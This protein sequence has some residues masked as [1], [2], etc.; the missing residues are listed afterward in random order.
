MA[1]WLANQSRP[2][3]VSIEGQRHRM[4][5][6]LGLVCHSPEPLGRISWAVTQVVRGFLDSLGVHAQRHRAVLEIGQQDRRD[7]PVI[8]QYLTLGEPCLRPVDLLQVRDLDRLISHVPC[9]C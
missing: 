2:A 4:I 9:F 1:P 3:A 6:G 8:L 5:D 7:L